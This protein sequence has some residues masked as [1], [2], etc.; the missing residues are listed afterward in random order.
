MAIVTKDKT[1]EEHIKYYKKL[2]VKEFPNNNELASSSAKGSIDQKED[3]NFIFDRNERPIQ[4]GEIIHSMLEAELNNKEFD[5][6]S[7]NLE[8][9]EKDLLEQYKNRF[10]SSE[11][12]KKALSASYRKTEYGFITKYQGK[13]D[14]K[15]KTT[16]G[17][18]D[19][20]FEYENVVYIVD[21]KTD[22][23]KSDQYNRQ[24]SVYKKAVKDLLQ[25]S[26]PSKKLEIKT[27]LFYLHL[28]EIV[29]YNV[30]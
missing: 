18:I 30:D 2:E 20:F 13:E 21:Y 22:K 12:G 19:L 5:I 16:R 14:T 3:K 10:F 15:P 8:E 7:F 4:L 28:N 9:S 6:S 26:N 1:I 23:Q 17:V 29:D 27:I 24:L 11:I 25:H